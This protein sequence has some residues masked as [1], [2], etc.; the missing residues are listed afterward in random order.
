VEK[1]RWQ[2]LAESLESCREG[3]AKRRL[4]GE[5]FLEARPKEKAL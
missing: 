5:Q 3:K 1:E 2:L 4:N